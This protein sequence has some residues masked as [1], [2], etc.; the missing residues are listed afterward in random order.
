MSGCCGGSCGTGGG[1]GGMRGPN[2]GDFQRLLQQSFVINTLTA[3]VLLWGGMRLDSAALMAGGLGFVAG[4]LNYGASLWMVRRGPAHGV[5]GVALNTI[6]KN[7]VLALAGVGVM[8]VAVSNAALGLIPDAPP[9]SLLA[10]AGA[11]I[12]LVLATLLFAGRQ[13]RGRGGVS[14][15]AV[16]LCA[17]RDVLALAAVMAAAAGVWLG[18]VPWPDTAVALGLS[19]VTLAGLLGRRRLNHPA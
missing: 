6:V 19:G 14:G 4:A 2:N 9:V 8:A 17:R 7:A 5:G 12:A 11:G 10:L 18:G 13:N 1:G 16:W 15:R 3:A